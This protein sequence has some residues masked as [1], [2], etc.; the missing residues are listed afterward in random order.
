MEDTF[1][2]W[3]AASADSFAR[4]AK[5]PVQTRG[6]GRFPRE[7]FSA[8]ILGIVCPLVTRQ[9]P[10]PRKYIPIALF[11][12]LVLA[13][14]TDAASTVNPDGMVLVEWMG[15]VKVFLHQRHNAIC[16]T[17]PEP[18]ASSLPISED[19]TCDV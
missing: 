5:Q 19:L 18:F 6:M 3:I 15:Y 17:V 1:V 11:V 7:N 13:V 16:S 9:H 12:A 2:I 8:A 10:M 14:A 4:F